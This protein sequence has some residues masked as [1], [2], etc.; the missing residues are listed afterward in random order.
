M[1]RENLLVSLLGLQAGIEST[2]AATTDST[3][4]IEPTIG[5]AVSDSYVQS[6]GPTSTTQYA[7]SEA[8]HTSSASP[9]DTAGEASSSSS[10][11]CTTSMSSVM[12]TYAGVVPSTNP[13]TFLSTAT[14]DDPSE[15]PQRGESTSAPTF[16][17]TYATAVV[18][19][20]SFG[21]YEQN[22]ASASLFPGLVALNT[23][24]YPSQ[25][26]G[27]TAAAQMSDNDRIP[28]AVIS[29]T[30]AETTGPE[31]ETTE[32]PNALGVLF[33]ALPSDVASSIASELDID[34]TRFL[35]AERTSRTRAS[36]SRPT[37]TTSTTRTSSASSI[38]T[39]STRSSSTASATDSSATTL[40]PTANTGNQLRQGSIAGIATGVTAGVVLILLTALLLARRRQQGKPF[41]G[42]MQRSTSK[43]SNR[44]YPEVAWLYDPATTPPRTSEN[45]SRAESGISL[46]PSTYEGAAG[47]AGGAAGGRFY[48][49]PEARPAGPESPLLP[50]QLLYARDESPGSSPTGNGRGRSARSSLQSVARMGPIHEEPHVH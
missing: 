2:H 22:E 38:F 48:G 32:P 37:D 35:P 24:T 46:L 50:P 20:T 8:Q 34:T 43:R 1:R 21:D 9:Y 25:A 28:T 3:T 36:T 27:A 14:R 47:V 49:N 15:P 44:A 5:A 30:S 6:T 18:V 23:D 17:A 26:S 4:L 33:S 12:Q 40:A 19:H 31:P 39:T 10:P 13:T 16:L 41:F 45:H 29:P 11:P 42:A 7:S